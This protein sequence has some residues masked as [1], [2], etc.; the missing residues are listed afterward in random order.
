[1]ASRISVPRLA[2]LLLLLALTTG[3]VRY[4]FRGAL[5]SYIDSIAIPAFEDRSRWVGLQEKLYQGT[6]NAFIEDGTLRVLDEE[7]GAALLMTG[8]IQ[9]VRRRRT[10]VAGDET[11]EEEQLVVSVRIECLNRETNKPLWSGTVSDFG[12]VSGSAGLDEQEAAI[13]EAVEK[14]IKDIVNRTVAAW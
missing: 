8:A 4:S 3:C 10:S 12:V 13:D 5:P 9:E 1:M 7:T 11:V 2:G 6:V 14:V